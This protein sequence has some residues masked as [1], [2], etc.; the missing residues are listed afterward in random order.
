MPDQRRPRRLFLTKRRQSMTSLT[1]IRAAVEA[2][3][4]ADQ[5]DENLRALIVAGKAEMDWYLKG[6]EALK[7]CRLLRPDETAMPEV[8][9]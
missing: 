9:R 7:I 8:S 3:F 1:E 2:T 6:E 4:D 5:T